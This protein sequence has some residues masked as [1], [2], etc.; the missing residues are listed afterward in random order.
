LYSHLLPAI[1]AHFHPVLSSCESASAD[2]SSYTCHSFR[3]D[4]QIR[5]D[6]AEHLWDS[7]T[8]VRLM[9]G[10]RT[11][12]L[13]LHDAARTHLERTEFFNNLCR[14]HGFVDQFALN[15]RSQQ[16]N[17]VAFMA[18]RDIPFTATERLMMELLHPHVAIALRRL[19]IESL[20][21]FGTVMAPWL[22]LD[23][24][25]RPYSVTRGQ[26]AVLLRYFPH[27]LPTPGSLPE[28]L[29]MWIRECA[30]R[31]ATQPLAQ[32]LL[33]FRVDSAHG[34]LVVRFF[35]A[36]GKAGAALRL[37]ETPAA[38]EF[39]FWGRLAGL[40]GREREVLRW[41]A[42]GKRDA[43]IAVILDISAATARKHVEHI[44]ARLG[45][46][47]RTTAVRALH[48]ASRWREN[49]ATPS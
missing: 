49:H 8:V 38:R 37:L 27:W 11:P 30:A 3:S 25:A 29:R 16:G 40:T 41:M 21:S 31:L 48:A 19:E 44:L 18:N 7:P 2:G 35:P 17:I 14:P 12:V 43:E 36:S 32:P 6:F 4:V 34:H 20:D 46:D 42:A 13:Q 47:S 45:T 23:A 24:H 15:I 5:R 39:R 22:E 9:C 1:D 26:S 33:A 10:D 28:P